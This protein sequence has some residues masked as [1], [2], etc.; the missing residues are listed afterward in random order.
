MKGCQ[1]RDYISRSWEFL[2]MLG[3]FL[4]FIFVKKILGS[5]MGIIEIALKKFYQYF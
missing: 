5:I 3:F 1:I 2:K 4:G